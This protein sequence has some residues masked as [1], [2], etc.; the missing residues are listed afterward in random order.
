MQREL[1]E[2]AQAGDHEAFTVLARSS[3]ARM[4]GIARLILRDADRAQDAVQDALVLAWRHIRALRDPDAWD[5]WL[6]RLTVRACYKAA[7]AGR[8]RDLVELHVARDHRRCAR[9][10]LARRSPVRGGLRALRPAGPQG[11][12]GA[13]ALPSWGRAGCHAVGIEPPATAGYRTSQG[14]VP[15]T[16]RSSKTRGQ[17]SPCLPA[18][19]GGPPRVL[20]GQPSANAARE[21]WAGNGAPQTPVPLR[22]RSS[23][24]S[25]TAT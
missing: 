8:R 13:P 25:R 24:S 1:V 14:A 5:G 10:H 23:P 15:L 19:G 22:I 21:A 6:H 11:T 16:L 4:Y 9:A 17:V 7:R 12:L 18:P 2:L 3:S 20:T